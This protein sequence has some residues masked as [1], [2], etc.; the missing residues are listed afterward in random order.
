MAIARFDG[1]T[2]GSNSGWTARFYHENVMADGTA[3]RVEIIDSGSAAGTFSQSETTVEWLDTVET[4]FLLEYEGATDQRHEPLVPSTCTLHLVQ[5]SAAQGELMDAIHANADHR[6][7]IAL[8]TFE[9]DENSDVNGHANFADATGYWRPMW[10]GTIMADQGESEHLISKRQFTITAQCGL[11]LLNDEPFRTDDD[12]PF[13]GENSLAVQIAR[14]LDKLPTSTLWGWNK[15]DG[16][17]SPD[18]T[19]LDESDLLR[20]G[21]TDKP[22]TPFFREAVW[23]QDR[24]NHVPLLG[25][26][27]DVPGGASVLQ[28]TLCQ[29]LAFVDIQRSD[30]AMG[31]TVRERKYTSC[32]EV[33]AQIANVFGAQIFLAN[34]SWFFV[35]PEV[36]LASVS[37]SGAYNRQHIWWTKTKMLSDVSHGSVTNPFDTSNMDVFSRG[38]DL[39]EGVTQTVLFPVKAVASVHIEGGTR[40]L[41]QGSQN[42]FGGGMFGSRHDHEGEEIFAVREASQFALDSLTYSNDGAVI[43]GGQTMTMSGRLAFAKLGVHAALVGYDWNTDKARGAKYKVSMTI[44]CGSYYLKRDIAQR[45]ETAN[46]KNS[47]GSTVAT[48]K[49]FEQSGDIEWTTTAET[50]DIVFPRLGCNPEAATVELTAAGET[51]DFDFVGGFHTERRSNNPA[52]F[53]TSSGTAGIGTGTIQTGSQFEFGWTLPNLPDGVDHEGVEVT[54]DFQL[55]DSQN[56]AITGSDNVDFFDND[57]TAPEGAQTVFARM[58]EFDLV[59][60][61][62]EEGGDVEFVALSDQNTTKIVTCESV[63]GDFY[64]ETQANRGMRVIDESDGT[65]KT[66][67]A[68][69]WV[70]GDNIDAGGKYIHALRASETLQKREKPV[71]IRTTQLA[72]TDHENIPYPLSTSRGSHSNAAFNILH[73]G[74]PI[75]LG[76]SNGVNEWFHLM[77]LKMS[78]DGYEFTMCKLSSARDLTS[79]T[80]ANDTR[81]PRGP[82]PMHTI[83][84]DVPISRNPVTQS[85]ILSLDRKIATNIS[86]I[87]EEA[88]TRA[89]ADTTLQNNIDALSDTVSDEAAARAAGDTANATRA[90]EI[91]LLN[92]FFQK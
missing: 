14:C 87:T 70:T 51:I 74:R 1:T 47:I 60:G 69:R 56:N 12:Q 11:V 8:F 57:G 29:S 17:T 6:F 46:I 40:R 67:S 88:Q 54:F 68:D 63:L 89:A 36:H 41:A 83:T 45:S 32:G 79:I 65:T 3:I 7:G 15:Y 92:L 50:Y 2:S 23:I 37:G 84:S 90:D 22:H 53:R 86:D 76:Y 72:F 35:N 26:T 24:D 59:M 34:G 81:I 16:T 21:L 61:D 4:S 39:S 18:A 62:G 13:Q 85:T 48:A 91:E 28:H 30:D 25:G 31:G 49:F 20:S 38:F 77:E 73:F 78:S 42:N 71:V 75:L 44:K 5:T 55:L 9:P 10:F 33:L 58:Y 80:E 82:R 43:A 19:G 66:A 27:V 52:E 64:E